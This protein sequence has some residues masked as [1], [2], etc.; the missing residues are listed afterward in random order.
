[1][2][3][4]TVKQ[5]VHDLEMPDAQLT[6]S[7]LMALCLVHLRDNAVKTRLGNERIEGIAETI[8]DLLAKTNPIYRALAEK[9]AKP[10]PMI[11]GREAS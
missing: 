1:M 5:W 8:D 9:R 2:E 6:L 4:R 3:R 11:P 7:E 10:V